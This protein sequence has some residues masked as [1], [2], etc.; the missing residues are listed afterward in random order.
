MTTTL[1]RIRPKRTPLT[2]E[3]KSKILHVLARLVGVCDGPG[4]KHG[5]PFPEVQTDDDTTTRMPLTD[6]GAEVVATARRLLAE[7]GKEP[8][9]LHPMG[10]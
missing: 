2:V 8:V 9:P 7:Y 3:E 4:V 5:Y 6:Q 10:S 1:H